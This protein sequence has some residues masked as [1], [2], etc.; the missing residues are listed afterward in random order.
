[1]GP[2]YLHPG[3]IGI[4]QDLDG[5]FY[6]S[7]HLPRVEIILTMV[8]MKQHLITIFSMFYLISLAN[9]GESFIQLEGALLYQ[10]RNVQGIPGNTGT[11]FSISEFDQGP[12]DALRLYL[13]KTWNNRHEFRLLFAPLK[14]ETSGQFNQNVNF[15]GKTFSPGA[16]SAVYQFN[17]YRLTYA[18]QF[19]ALQEWVLK[20]GGT[21]LVRDAEVA[22]SQGNQSSSKKNL[23]FV[24]LINFQAEKK[25]SETWKF[26][27]DFD[28]LAAPQGRAFDVAL[29][30][31][32]QLLPN[33][34]LL[35]GYR[36]LEGGADNDSVYN[37]AWF[38]YA[39]VGLRGDF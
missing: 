2:R 24:P 22:L 35:G 36:M 34:S 11:R 14:I 28:G 12:F 6:S 29:F 39:T 37:M 15:N 27:F 8:F 1:M 30:L 5:N 20:L 17:S 9:A 38:H 4:S 18:Y 25:L 26:R 10:G 3:I 13:G 32:R 31:E 16:V 33:F 19:E 21:L 23:G 7:S